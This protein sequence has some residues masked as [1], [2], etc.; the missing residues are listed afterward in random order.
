MMVNDSDIVQSGIAALD[1][2]LHNILLGDNVVWQV[3]QLDDYRYFAEHFARQAMQDRRNLIYLRFASHPPILEPRSG[4]TVVEVDPESGFDLFSAEIHKIVEEQGEEAFYVFDNLST[5]VKEWGTDELL[6]NFFLVT[7]P[8]LFEL[9]TVAYF[10]LKL[11]THDDNTV[12]RIRETTQLLINVYH[13]KGKRYL[14]PQKV[15]NRYS[16]QMFMPHL[17]QDD[18]ILPI[19]HSGDAA[20]ITAQALKYPLR[21]GV[22]G[23]EVI[24]PWES[25]YRKLMQFYMDE[26][27]NVETIPEVASLKQE[28]IRMILGTNLQFCQLVEK[29]F[30]L[31]D[32]FEIRNRIVGSGRIGGKAAGMLLARRILQQDDGDGVF[33]NVLDNHD[34]FY[35][36]SDVFFTFLVNNNLFKLRLQVT[37]GDL[38]DYKEF[39]EIEARFL[40]AKFNQEAMAQFQ[41]MINYFG[42]S[43]IIVRSSSMLEDSY[44]NSF[45]GKYRSEFCANQG[46]PEERMENFL[47]AV[48]LVYASALNP[49]AL[50]YRR[51]RG[52]DQLDERMAL[53]VQ[54]VSGMPYKQCFFPSLAGVAFSRN[55][56]AWT[57]RIDPK[58]GII[59][60]VF[61]LGTR[62]VD[63]TGGDYP[64]LIPIGN[65]DL[66]PETGTQVVKYSQHEIDLLDLQSNRLD[67]R[68]V[69]ELISDG[70]Y[71]NLHLMVSLLAHN[72]I[73]DPVAAIFM[74]DDSEFVLTFNNLIRQTNFV[75]IMGKMLTKLEAVHGHPIDI[76]FTAYIDRNG[77]VRINLLQCRF[78]GLP[79]TE[80][81]VSLPTDIPP[82]RILFRSNRI[83][84]GGI[85]SE[86]RFIILIDPAEYVT[87]RDLDFKKSFGRIVGRI[88]ALPDIAEGKSVMIGPGRW[89]SS[90][91]DLGVNVH[92]ADINNT[93]VLVEIAREEYGQIPDVSYGTHF[94]QDLVESQIMYLPVFPNDAAAQFNSDFFANAPNCLTQFLP[95][96][97]AYA[98]AIKLID[99]PKAANGTSF[100]VVADPE[101]QS[102]VCYLK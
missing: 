14:H 42:Q 91:I 48:K 99:V 16:S 26:D 73:S 56:Y 55:L 8:L 44:K 24:A 93:S 90:H 101:S 53:L 50:A 71:P 70:R 54:R 63:R 1:R 52:L 41:N 20:K 30:R 80:G 68:S 94:F 78:M 95:D 21:S 39:E 64:R 85:V 36:G 76:E 9:R 84:S 57:D 25:V 102:A 3:E 46:S 7:C 22:G 100:H 23:M 31:E 49:D 62:A 43:P 35:I 87:I 96:T 5:L 51:K 2:I 97:A 13:I 4:L 28:L 67:T 27:E 40:N 19:F 47:R 77:R 89:G 45:A 75:D 69:D 60:L 83:M 61:G 74:E 17:I 58:R 65:P 34:S 32:L 37:Q 12:A 92:Y 98:R 10:G 66:R 81:P 18:D 11:E 59:R 88:N 86:I 82:E 29:Y 72:H 6:A 79:G 15:W 38:I 33:T